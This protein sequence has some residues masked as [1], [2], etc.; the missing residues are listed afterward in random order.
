MYNNQLNLIGPTITVAY[1][2][3]S[4]A[5][6]AA[7]QCN[8]VHLVSTTDCFV[9][10]GD[11]ATNAGLFLPAKVPIVVNVND[12]SSKIAVIRSSADGSLYVTPAA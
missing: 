11:T 3:A 1:T 4:A 10:F 12:P 9:V 8:T 2:S 6:A 5:S 7:L